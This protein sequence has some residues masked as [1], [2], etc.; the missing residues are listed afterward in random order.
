MKNKIN[1]NAILPSGGQIYLF[2]EIENK[3]ILL[4]INDLQS[5]CM[6][7]NLLEIT[8]IISFVLSAIIRLICTVKK[9]NNIKGEGSLKLFIWFMFIRFVVKLL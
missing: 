2:V 7:I 8:Y 3:N 1:P 6:I 5:R 4:S 9:I